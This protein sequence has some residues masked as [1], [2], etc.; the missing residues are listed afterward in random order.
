MHCIEPSEMEMTWGCSCL[1][2]RVFRLLSEFFQVSEPTQGGST[3]FFH[4]SERIF[5]SLTAYIGGELGIFPSPQGGVKL[6]IF[7]KSQSV[8]GGRAWN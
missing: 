6:R 1:S 8:Y 7:S 2:S 5:T 4:V 3:E